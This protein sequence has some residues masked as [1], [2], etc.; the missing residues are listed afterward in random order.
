MTK[1]ILTSSQMK[2]L[3]LIDD[4]PSFVLLA[5]DLLEGQG[6]AVSR[7]RN[8]REALTYLEKSLPDLLVCDIMMPELDGYRFV[9]EVR[10]NPHLS[11]L[12]VIFLSA[13][14]E[15]TDRIK[16]LKGGADAYLVKPFEP[17]ELVALVEALLSRTDRMANSSPTFSEPL[18]SMHLDFDVALTPTEA[19]VLQHVARGQS[20]KEIAKDLSVSQRTIESHVSNMLIKTGLSNRTELTRW[21][22]ES[23]YA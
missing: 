22:I 16:G 8:G 11:W 9:Q 20:N 3:L 7:A 23:H 2:S 19:K 12:P 6:Y 17:E 5:G 18:K 21:A 13:K 4:D 10:A 1:S 15:V 14:G